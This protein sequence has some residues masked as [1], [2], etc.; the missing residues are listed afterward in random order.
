MTTERKVLIGLIVIAAIVLGYVWFKSN[1]NI[2]PIPW[3]PPGP[4]PAPDVNPINQI[5][6]IFN[7]A[8]EQNKNIVLFFTSLGCVPCE[9][10]KRDVFTKPDVQRALSNY[11]YVE[12]DTTKDPATGRL[13]QVT[14][15][16]TLIMANGNKQIVKIQQG[17]V[18]EQQ[19]LLWLGAKPQQQPP[20]PIPPRRQRSPGG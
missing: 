1:P 15:V 18:T 8:K 16:P 5:D 19:M 9:Q 13:F 20:S 7:Q 12:I 11:I 14:N 6:T 2:N 17:S 4:G 10:M 3:T